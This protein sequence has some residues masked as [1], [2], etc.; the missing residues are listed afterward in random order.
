MS[1]NSTYVLEMNH[2]TKEFPGVRALNDV[3]IKVKPGEIHALIGENGAGKSTLMKIL[4][5]VYPAGTYK[6]EILL[7]GLPVELHSPHDARVKGIGFVPQETS[8]IEGLSVSEN[9]FVGHLTGERGVVVRFGELHAKTAQFL[10]ECNINL[11]PRQLVSYLS[12]SQRQLVMIARALSMNPSVLILDEATSSLTL[13]EIGNLFRILKHLQ[14]RGVTCIFITHKLSEIFE[15][16]DQV[17]VL[18]D[19]VVVAG[20]D[21]GR[22]S[23]DDI[24]TAMVGRRID[25]LYPVRDSEIGE[26]EVLRVQDLTVPHMQVAGKNMVE[27]ISFSVYRGEILGIAG[28]VGSGR[29]EVVNAIY[30]RTINSGRIF[31]EGREVRIASPKDA[32]DNG[33][34]LVT[35]DRK[36]DG[37]LFN[38]ALRENITINSLNAVSRLQILDKGRESRYA[39]DYVKKLA[40]RTPSIATMVS[41]LSGGNQQ[42]VVLGKVLLTKPK[43]LLLDEPTKGVDVGAKYEIYKLMMELV[44]QGISLVV[45]SSELPELLALCDRFIVLA[46]G[47]I[48]D[49]FTKA[50]A[51]EHRVMMAATLAN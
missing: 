11:N 41:N 26:K 37:L 13:D 50:E 47:K 39:N 7:N 29:S 35:E 32:K 49:Q 9:I 45:I 38:F 5:G 14:Q 17:T 18:R 25:N 23:Q 15:V 16:A 30:G 6:G 36:R 19:G 20:F 22:F 48:R 46:G 34:G 27:G 4:N 10:K 1:T 44:R 12:A 43:V 33:I 31:V 8:V 21:R 2:I 28:L 24:I 42:K 40:I 3:T 51:S